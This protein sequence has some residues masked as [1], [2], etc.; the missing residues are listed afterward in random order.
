MGCKRVCSPTSCPQNATLSFGFARTTQSISSN[1]QST[2]RTPFEPTSKDCDDTWPEAFWYLILAGE[3]GL[4]R[5]EPKWLK[6]PAVSRVS[7]SSP[8]YFRRFLRR[9]SDAP[10]EARVKP[11]GFL[12]SAQV[13]RFSHPAGADPEAFHLL[14]PYTSSPEKW[15]SELWTDASPES[16]SP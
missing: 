16:N 14:A 9:F 12:L 1:A 13:A 8:G 4:P 6:L 7:I 15:S 11:Y 2:D 3:L 5:D 10:Y